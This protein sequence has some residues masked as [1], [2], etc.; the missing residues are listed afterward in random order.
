MPSVLLREVETT[1]GNINVVIGDRWAAL[2]P[3]ESAEQVKFLVDHVNLLHEK[4]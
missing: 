4:E 2:F 1:D 3:K